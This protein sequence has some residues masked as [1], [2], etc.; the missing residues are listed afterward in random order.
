MLGD[1]HIMDGTIRYY[2]LPHSLTSLNGPIH[3]RTDAIDV[4]ELT[5]RMG[6]GDVTFDGRLILAEGYRPVEFDITAAGR[7]M[8]LRYPPGVRSTV[9]A[10]LA[11]TGP[12]NSPLLSGAIT[13]HHL[14]YSP[15][16]ED[17]TA[18]VGLA[19]GGAA[20]VLGPG[21]PA[22]DTSAFPLRFDITVDMETQPIIQHQNGSIEGSAHLRFSGTYDRPSLTGQVDIESGEYFF[23][24]NR[25]FVR[26][27]TIDFANPSRIQPIFDVQAETRARA[28][29]QTFQVGIRL[30]GTFDRITP[31]LTSDPWLPDE[32]II[33][34]LLGGTPDLGRLE[35]RQLGSP[36]QAQQAML[37]NAGAVLLTSPI[38]S[39][40]G[41]A[42]TEALPLTNVQIT[43][44]L[45]NTDSLQQLNP[46]ARITVGRRISNNVYLTYSVA[47]NDAQSE[48]I[49]LE[50]DQ[51]DRLSWVL[52]RNGD[53]TFALDFRIRYVF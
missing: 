47:L 36:Q 41:N 51:S 25:Y 29:G 10:D 26:R 48:L 39:R 22:G 5:A 6:E 46:S 38:S 32:E 40:L 53:R 52:S 33:S 31:T 2:G 15:R 9:D 44:M 4:S 1:A 30:S 7:S 12:I 43:P 8:R 27:G 16:V 20:S 14:D 24:G 50:Y 19:S 13:V 37:Q 49:L 21:E 17:Q 42:F 45:G 23:A 34:L 18:I 35:Q 3:F 28:A 11:L